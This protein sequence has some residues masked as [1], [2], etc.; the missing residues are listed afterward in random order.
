M[1]FLDRVAAMA[2]R[3]MLLVCVLVLSGCA[4][5]VTDY[6]GETPELDLAEFFNG[7][8]KAWGMVQNRSGKVVR[9]F[10]VD[11]IGRWDG[12]EGVLEED[13]LFADGQTQRRVW[14]F[15]KVDRHTY[16]GTAGDVVGE[17][18]G[19]VYGNALRWRYVLALEVDGKTWNVNFDDWM[20]LLDGRTMM[21]R[22]EMKKFGLRLGEVTLFFRK[23][24]SDSP[25]GAG[26]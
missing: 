18:T 12:D 6:A 14:R 16:T 2:R 5:K 20:Y 3:W 19:E 9:R 25:E 24:E 22:S 1:T 10:E 26:E 13:F 23:P 4:A 8:V 15:K 17:A 11:M 21:N 7:P